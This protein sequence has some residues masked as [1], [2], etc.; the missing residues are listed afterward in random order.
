MIA[1]TDR[2]TRAIGR[3]HPDLTEGRVRR[4]LPA[5]ILRSEIVDV[6]RDTRGTD[7]P[8][9]V[10]FTPWGT[11]LLRHDRRGE[12]TFV[13]IA[14]VTEAHARSRIAS[15]EWVVADRKAAP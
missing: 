6:A 2:I 13:A 12:P 4:E 14:T 8:F 7:E 11:I 15:G 1:I 10:A 9:A 3:T 5:L